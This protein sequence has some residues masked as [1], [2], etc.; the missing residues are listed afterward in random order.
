MDTLAWGQHIAKSLINRCGKAYWT[1]VWPISYP[2]KPSLRPRCVVIGAYWWNDSVN[3]GDLLTPWVLSHFGV[4]CVHV[5]VQKA[6]LVGIGSIIQDLSPAWSGVV[7]GSGLIEDRVIE[8]PSAKILALR[9]WLTAD[10]LGRH[11]VRALG[12]P[13]LLASRCIDRPEAK[14][15]LGICPH[16]IHKHDPALKRIASA[17]QS[18]KVVDV[19]RGPEHVV[20]EISACRVVLTSSLHGLIVADSFGIPAAWTLLEPHVYGGDFKFRDYESVLNSLESRRVELIGNE[21]IC[22]IRRVARPVDSDCLASVQDMLMRSIDSLKEELGA[23]GTSPFMA[24]SMF[25]SG[26]VRSWRKFIGLIVS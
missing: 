14:W 19:Q 8:L 2:F 5:E 12:D 18:V 13:G 22:D 6:D 9:G 24:W 20:R 23:T 16:D 15:D 17:G 21:S 3:F 25:L 7:W 26:V 4:A 1:S 11:D 10:R